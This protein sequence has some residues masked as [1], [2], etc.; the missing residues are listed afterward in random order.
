MRRA[1]ST[2]PATMHQLARFV[3]EMAGERL[4]RSR[5]LWQFWIVEGLADGRIAF[6]GKVHHCALDGGA[7]ADLM[8]AFFGI[9]PEP[10]P[11]ELPEA[12]PLTRPDDL[13]LLVGAV[14]D[15]APRLRRTRSA[16]FGRLGR[17]ARGDPHP[18][19]ARAEARAAPRWLTP[20]TPY[21]GAITTE[22]AIAF[23]RLPLADVKAVRPGG[24]RHRQRR[25]CWRPVPGAFRDHLHARRRPARPPLVAGVPVSASASDR[26]R[27]ETGNKISACS[28]RCTPRSRT[29]RSACGPRSSTATPPSASSHRR[30]RHHP[31]PGRGL[32]P[33]HPLGTQ[34]LLPHRARR[35]PPPAVN[36]IVSNIVGPPFP[37]YLGG[38]QAE[39]LYPMGPVIEGPGEPHRDELRR[40]RRHRPARR[41]GAGP[42]PV[43]VTAAC[44]GRST[45]SPE[46]STP[47]RRG[48]EPRPAASAHAPTRPSDVGF[49]GRLRVDCPRRPGAGER[50]RTPMISSGPEPTGPGKGDTMHTY[51]KFFIGGE[52]VEPCRLRHAQGA[53]AHHPGHRRVGAGGHHRR[54]GRAPSPPPAR[55][56]TAARGPTAAPRAGRRLAKLAQ[57]IKD[58]QGD[59]TSPHHRGDRL[60]LLFSM[61]GQ[62]L[63]AAMVLDTFSDPSCAATRSRRSARAPSAGPI[64]VRR[65]PVGVCAGIIPWN[66]PLFITALKLGPGAGLGLHH[67]AQA[68]TRDAARR[69]RA[70]RDPRRRRRARRAWSTSS[71]PTARSASTWCA[72]PASTR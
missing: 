17:A 1:C 66:V 6:A 10:A 52:W 61:F 39:R 15:R 37:I 14:G 27:G 51:D 40:P 3:A 62:V 20:A 64:I 53:V 38:A 54:H 59:F 67:R 36:A 11:V 32:D 2:R 21:N 34:R 13:H 41:R 22:R 24:G 26:G 25:A 56:S 18:P 19:R 68:R 4:D 44:R 57:G 42:G 31:P 69:Q 47:S 28:C 8:P 60:A 29:P 9:E 23:G 7:A 43:G 70:G 50:P 5:P 72:T 71:P 46:P 16:R 45:R 63:A 48:P 12:A 30:Q 65:E 49:R 58:R 55:R 33:H 35:P